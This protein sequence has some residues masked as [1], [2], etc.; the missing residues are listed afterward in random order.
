M[1]NFSKPKDIGLACPDYRGEPYPA[2]DEKKVNES[3]FE[4]GL[5]A[6]W[7]DMCITS[8]T[9]GNV[10]WESQEDD[11]P[12]EAWETEIKRAF[13]ANGLKS[14]SMIHVKFGS[15]D[16]GFIHNYTLTI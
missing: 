10:T 6:K 5:R 15:R 7:W 11:D 12:T 3:R 4:D 13:K 14:G 9:T 8:P 2:F 16:S 1:S